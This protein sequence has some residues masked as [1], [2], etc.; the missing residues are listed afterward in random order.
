MNCQGCDSNIPLKALLICTCYKPQFAEP[1]KMVHKCPCGT[2]NYTE[3]TSK[4][5]NIIRKIPMKDGVKTMYAADC[6]GGCSF[7][8]QDIEEK[9]E[10]ALNAS[11]QQCL[12]VKRVLDYLPENPRD[13]IEY[14]GDVLSEEFIEYVKSNNIEGVKISDIVTA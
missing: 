11:I 4:L 6:C 13:R 10:V 7:T 5:L 8:K 1:N 2:V 12:Y 14:K 3:G 9:Y